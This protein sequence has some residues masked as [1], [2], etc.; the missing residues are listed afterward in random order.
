[1]NPNRATN[2]HL[3]SHKSKSGCSVVAWRNWKPVLV[4]LVICLSVIL[5]GCATKSASRWQLVW[6]DEFNGT[7]VDLNK[8]EFEI[9]AWGGGNNELQYYIT[10][11]ASV[12]DGCLFIEGRRENYAGQE[13]TREFTS[14][15]MR[16]KNRGDWKY[17]RFEMRAKLPT[18]RG[19][20]PAFWTLPTDNV[21][22][23]WP[24]SGEIDIMEVLGHKP[25]ELHGTLH[26]ADTN[27]HHMYRG[28]N[29][30]LTAGTF[31][32]SFHVFAVEWEADSIKWFL[33]GRLYQT[34]TNWT[35]GT[36]NFPAPFDQR[37]HIILNLAIGGHW[38]GA[39][40]AATK[41]PQAM[42]VDHVRVYQRR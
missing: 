22:G 39:P 19:F 30:T 14:S 31:T 12:H 11:N 6:Q 29:T 41:F 35:S 25:A 34:Q 32:D 21:Y 27:R 33:D 15:R 17:G 2:G 10:N 16:T 8:W 42:I 37:F 38:P 18:G 1:M 9:N 40:D 13:G 5:A 7:Q 4:S 24:H 26:F 28:T 23:G 20:W 36:N 3:I